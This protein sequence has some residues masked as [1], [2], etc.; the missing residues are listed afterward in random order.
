[1]VAFTESRDFYAAERIRLLKLDGLIA[2]LY[3]PPDHPLPADFTRY[4]PPEYYHMKETRHK[5]LHHDVLKPDP[6]VLLDILADL[7]LSREEVVYVGDKIFKDVSMAIEAG[8]RD[9][10]AKYGEGHGLEGYEL[11]RFVSHWTKEDVQRE[12]HLQTSRQVKAS[13]TLEKSFSEIVSLFEFR[14]HER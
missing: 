3:S 1:M 8:V 11:L 14:A 2:Y 5:R 12:Q 6:A 10:H 9:V 13:N 7:A 4:Y